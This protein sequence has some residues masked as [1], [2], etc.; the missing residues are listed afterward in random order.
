MPMVKTAANQASQRLGYLFI[1]VVVEC[2]NEI[3][4]QHDIFP[5]LENE[6]VYVKVFYACLYAFVLVIYQE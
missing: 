5:F 4:Y 3:H 1:K 6:L 2:N